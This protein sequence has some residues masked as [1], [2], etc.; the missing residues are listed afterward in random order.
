MLSRRFMSR[1]FSYKRPL[2]YVKVISCCP[3]K[4]HIRN[5]WLLCSVQPLRAEQCTSTKAQVPA[6]PTPEGLFQELPQELPQIITSDLWQVSLMPYRIW[7]WI[8]GWVQQTEIPA[9]ASAAGP[10][11]ASQAIANHQEREFPEV[12]HH[13]TPSTAPAHA[14]CPLPSI[15]C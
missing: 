1:F 10:A 5:K 2:D 9:Y 4:S 15:A 7:S 13:C 3:M 11:G 12:L 14:L 8:P 6:E